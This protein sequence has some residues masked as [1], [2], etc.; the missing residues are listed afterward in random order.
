MPNTNLEFAVILFS[1]FKIYSIILKNLIN[2]IEIGIPCPDY[3]DITLPFSG[4][5]ITTARLAGRI[6]ASEYPT[7]DEENT[8]D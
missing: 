4:I 3:A 7:L 5:P 8:S 6:L 1:M 2:K